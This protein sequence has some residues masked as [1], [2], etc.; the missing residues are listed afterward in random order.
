MIQGAE[1]A[2]SSREFPS[3]PSMYLTGATGGST[4]SSHRPETTGSVTSMGDIELLVANRLDPETARAITTL[5]RRAQEADDYDSLSEH[6]RMEL[7]AATGAAAGTASGDEEP[8]APDGATPTDGGRRGFAAV[9]ARRRGHPGLVGYAQ[10]SRSGGEGG[11]GGAG[12]DYGVEVVVDPDVRDPGQRV[13]DRLL[14][15]T[16]DQASH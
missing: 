2:C 15:A 13:A 1:L 6:K 14:G 12:G 3:Q 4:G 16:L 7:V 10:V 5:T 8:E 11:E 9:L